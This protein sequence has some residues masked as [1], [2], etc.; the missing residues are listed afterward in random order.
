VTW[1]AKAGIEAGVDMLMQM[2]ISTF[3]DPQVTTVKEAWNS[4]QWGRVS[5]AF[6]AGL[7]P[8]GRVIRSAIGA[9]GETLYWM[10]EMESQC[11]RV[12]EEEVLDQFAQNFWLFGISRGETLKVLEL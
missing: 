8:G 11:R 12:T 6:V 2:S 10:I 7:V 3:F 5:I 9:W 4:I 1:L